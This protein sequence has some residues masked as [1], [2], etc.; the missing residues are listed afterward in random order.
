[1]EKLR[2]YALLQIFVMLLMAVMLPACSDDK[3]GEP[4][5]PATHDQRLIGSWKHV[6]EV[7][8]GVE[9]LTIYTFHRDGTYECYDQWIDDDD[10]KVESDI[11]KGLWETDD[12]NYLFM[13]VTYSPNDKEYEGET[14]RVRYRI[15]DDDNIIIDGN[16][17]SRN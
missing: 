8:Y 1:M 11:V 10:E 9:D 2:K 3:E 6:W 4:A 15:V 13:E 14:E 17:F 5:D 7:A 16:Q 12:N